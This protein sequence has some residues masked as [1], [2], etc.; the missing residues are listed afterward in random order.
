MEKIELAITDSARNCDFLSDWL[1][2]STFYYVY[3]CTLQLF[4]QLQCNFGT[5]LPSI[6][7]LNWVYS[8]KESTKRSVPT[9]SSKKAARKEGRVPASMRLHILQLEYSP[10]TLV[11]LVLL[12]A[13]KCNHRADGP[14]CHSV[15]VSSTQ[16]TVT[17]RHEVIQKT[18]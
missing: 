11:D 6:R 16:A 5:L 1:L 12:L 7:S 15:R 10:I 2:N 13:M 9:S 4:T 14:H 3:F 17:S 8:V 18:S